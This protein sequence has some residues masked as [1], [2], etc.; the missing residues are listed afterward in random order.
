MFTIVLLNTVEDS[1]PRLPVTIDEALPHIQLELGRHQSKCLNPFVTACVDSGAWT[2]IGHSNFWHSLILQFTHIVRDIIIAKDCNYSIIN[3]SGI[4]KPIK[5]N[6]TATV[7]P[8]AFRI[9]IPYDTKSG[10]ELDIV[11]DCGKYVS[12]NFTLGNPFLKMAKSL[13]CF[14]INTIRVTVFIDGNYRVIAL[15]SPW[16]W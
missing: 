8:V 1:T 11:I 7:L 15:F 13:L 5:N 12:V 2:N 3:L 6:S 10:R 9:Y 14:E 16:W 4:I